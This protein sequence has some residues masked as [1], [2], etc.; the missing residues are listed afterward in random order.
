MP[1]CP[2]R[3]FPIAGFPRL[4]CL[5]HAANVRSEPGSNPSKC[6][7]ELP[8]CVSSNCWFNPPLFDVTQTYLTCLTIDTP[9]AFTPGLPL[10]DL[11]QGLIHA[12]KQRKSTPLKAICCQLVKDQQ[13]LLINF[14]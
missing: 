6:F 14:R 1:Y 13:R 3:R 4:A 11:G 10:A 12:D 5:I 7:E 2:L 9:R 8:T